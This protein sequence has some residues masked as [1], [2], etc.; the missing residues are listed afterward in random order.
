M[1][2]ILKEVAEKA[3]TTRTL[4]SLMQIEKVLAG[5]FFFKCLEPLALLFWCGWWTY[6]RRALTENRAPYHMHA[7]PMEGPFQPTINTMHVRILS[8]ALT[9]KR[10][11]S[12]KWRKI[13]QKIYEH[14]TYTH[15]IFHCYYCGYIKSLSHTYTHT[16][17][18]VTTSSHTGSKMETKN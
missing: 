12:R 17:T 11:L 14:Q 1:T 8:R 10:I 2:C 18:P 7:Q 5:L 15:L 16:C 3:K 6:T 9:N 13:R 4:S